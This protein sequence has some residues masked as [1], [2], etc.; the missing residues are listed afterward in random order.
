MHGELLSFYLHESDWHGGRLL[1]E[2]LLEEARRLGI[3]GGSA[4][5]AIAGY[6]RHGVLH[7]QHFF[8]L[9]GSVPVRV[10]FLLASDDAERLEALRQARCT[11]SSRACRCS[12]ACCR[13]RPAGGLTPGAVV[14][15]TADQAARGWGS[16]RRGQVAVEG[17][18]ARIELAAARAS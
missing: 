11:C 2:W 14:G 5:R 7:E 13:Q 3:P 17:I 4:F 6:G 15:R 12:S 18:R 1:Y 8:E 10:D 16:Q 9:A